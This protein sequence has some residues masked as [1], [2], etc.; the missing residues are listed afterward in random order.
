MPRNSGAFLG[1]ASGGLTKLAAALAGG[2]ASQQ[3][4]YDQEMM[5]QTK[6]GQAL[7]QMRAH[8][9]SASYDTARAGTETQRQGI[10]SSRPDLYEEQAALAAG[11]DIPTLRA[12]RERTRTG[13]APQVPMGPE[14]EAGGMGVG[15]AQFPPA[16]QSGLAR[17]LQQFLPLLANSGDL[18]PDDLAQAAQ[19]FRGMG[20]GDQV[21]SG[22]LP[23]AD[24]GRSQ[25]AVAGKPLFD[26]QASGTVL[27]QF[28]GALNESGGLARSNIAEN[29]AQAAHARAQ[30]DKARKE[31]DAGVKSGQIQVVTD[32]AGNITLLDKATGVAKPAIGADGQPLHGKGGALNEGQS[33]AL[34][35][36]NRMSAAADILGKLAESG[37]SQPSMLK[38]AAGAVPVVGDALAMGANAF[39]SDK[40]QQVEQAQRDFINA[41]LR[42]ESGAAISQGE[43]ANAAQQYFVQPNDKPGVKK[44]KREAVQR[45]IQSM[46]A[47]VP[48]SM[49]TVPAVADLPAQRVGAPRAEPLTR[50]PLRPA[51]TDP[52]GRPPL[53]SFNRGG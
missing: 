3:G 43:F 17:S 23:A 22:Q 1:G 37:V 27:D 40:Q 47:A 31:M 51:P 14:T 2:G 6:L 36:A 16:L 53:E 12:F 39:A 9:A 44:Q 48:E 34:G 28:S 45:A 21:L 50:M 4:A 7:A 38:R 42:R 15:S 29:Q 35:F 10:L 49:R 11:T 13:A 41:V 19:A 25:A 8:D 18:K 30:A 26:A 46:L 20:L 5:A 52:A 33:N 24:V 32:G